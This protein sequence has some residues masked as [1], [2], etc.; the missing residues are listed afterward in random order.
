MQ[1]EFCHEEAVEAADRRADEH[2]KHNDHG[3][4]QSADLRPHL[5]GHVSGVLQQRCRDTGGDT[6]GTA[7]GQ[8]G[9]GQHDTAADAQCGRQIGRRLGED[10]DEGCGF[11]EVGVLDGDVNDRNGHDDEQCVI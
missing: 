3:N 5:V 6:H 8:V 4:G 1:L 9:T 2:G 10:V 7:C 11:D